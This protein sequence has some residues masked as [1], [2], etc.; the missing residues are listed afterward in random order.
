MRTAPVKLLCEERLRQEVASAAHVLDVG[1]G[2]RRLGAHVVT[3]DIVPRA[4]LDVVADV[5]RGL[6]FEDGAFD[7]VVCTSVLEHVRDERTAIAEIRR[8]TRARV[9][10]EVPFLYHFHVSTAGDTADYRRWTWEGVLRLLDGFRILDHGHNV[11]P[12]TALRLVAAEVLA[13]PFYSERHTGAYDM[14]RWALGWLFH[15]L[16]LLDVS[17]SRKRVAGRAT[18]GFWILAKRMD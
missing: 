2:G 3:T 5:C 7:L 9:W 1:S 13:M 8:V 6:P 14:A 12:G 4:N 11:G 10:I 16:S 15:P 18:G 17:C